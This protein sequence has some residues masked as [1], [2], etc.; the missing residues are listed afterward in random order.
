MIKLN[1]NQRKFFECALDHFGNKSINIRLK[2]IN[3]FA[4]DNGLIVPTSILKKH[5]HEDT[6]KRGYYNLTLAGIKG[7]SQK[8]PQKNSDIECIGAESDVIHDTPDVIIET[9]SFVHNS[10]VMQ[11]TK[12][13]I[14]NCAGKHLLRYNNA[15]YILINANFE[16]VSVH[17]T[18]KG[19]YDNKHIVLHSGC[20]IDFKEVEKE[21]N[22]TGKCVIKS[23]N[24]NIWCCI[25]KE[26]L[27]E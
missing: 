14:F 1:K 8:I 26:E 20:D 12:K 10:G 23:N 7:L 18:A 24:S 6:Q 16:I 4:D 5:C 13:R 15:V 3:E 17:K 25:F 9:S 2:S 11:N 22:Y 21:L 27:R 19:A